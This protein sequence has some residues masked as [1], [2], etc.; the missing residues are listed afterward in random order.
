MLFLAKAAI[1]LSATFLMSAAYVFHEGVIKIDV[2]EHRGG[3]AHIHLW[4]PATVVDL[5]LHVVP[6]RNLEKAACETRPYLPALR[7]LA[8]ELKRYPDAQLVEVKD[9]TQ[10][11]KVAIVDGKIQI[12]V[13]DPEE[14]IH[15]RLPVETLEDVSDRLESSAPSI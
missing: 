10:H 13:V 5:G 9:A 8:K 1:G 12:D 6:T 7:E 4:V 11:V 14:T 2:D 3:G 15:V